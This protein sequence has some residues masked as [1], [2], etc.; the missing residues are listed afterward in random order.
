MI[1]SSNYFQFIKLI[2][3]GASAT[4]TSS[5][6]KIIEG[7]PYPTIT[8]IIGQPGYNTITEVPL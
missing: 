8:P 4:I 7:F 5:T 2:K 1:V 6:D 3:Q